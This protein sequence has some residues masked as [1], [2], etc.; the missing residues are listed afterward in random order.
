MIS[1]DVFVIV[2]I[3]S[4]LRCTNISASDIFSLVVRCSEMTRL[5]YFSQPMMSSLCVLN[6]SYFMYVLFFRR[7]DITLFSPNLNLLIMIDD[8]IWHRTKTILCRCT[9]LIY[10]NCSRYTCPSGKE[11]GWSKAFPFL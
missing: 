4:S 7:T 6:F 1:V 11:S 3:F 2:V 5:T 9:S 10:G 8:S